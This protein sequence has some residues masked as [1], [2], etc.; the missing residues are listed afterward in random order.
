[1][2][3]K[4]KTF[5]LMYTPFSTKDFLAQADASIK[6]LMRD[7]NLTANQLASELGIHPQ[8]MRRLIRQA[9]GM[10]SSEYIIDKKITHAKE[11]L[12]N[13]DLLTVAKVGYLCGFSEPTHFTRFF[14]HTVGMTPSQFRNQ[15]K[16]E[17]K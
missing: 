11:L 16:K 6:K 8:Q 2:Q 4:T 12:L 7:N 10:S 15:N 14:K 3:P 9:T 13:Q 5:S 1:M 17:N